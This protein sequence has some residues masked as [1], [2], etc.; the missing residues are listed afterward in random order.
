MNYGGN[1]P[2]WHQY[3]TSQTNEVTPST[4]NVNSG[5]LAYIPGVSPSTLNAISLNSEGLNK[6]QNNANYNPRNYQSFNNVSSNS[7]IPNNS[8]LASMVQMQNCIG[9]YG[10]PNTRNPMLDNINTSV[11]PRNTTI[12][13]VN[14]DI[15]YRSNQGPFNGPIGHLNGPNCNLNV[16]TGPRT[17]PGP[18]HGSRTNS[19]PGLGTNPN[20]ATGPGPMY[21]PNSRHGPASVSG[22]GSGPGNMGPRSTNVGPL[23]SGKPGPSSSCIP[24]KGMCCNSDSNINYQQWE[25]FGS[26]QN[27]GSYRDNVHPSNYQIEN[28]HFGNNCNFRKDNLDGKEVMGPVIPNASTIDHRRNFADYK[29]HKDHLVHRN[30][31]TS[32]GIFHNYSMQGYNY[33]AEHQK[34]PYP[35]K[36]HTKT[37][38]M[39]VQN[40]GMLKHQEQNFIAQQKFNNKQFQYQNGNMIPKGISTLNVNANMASSS[41]NPYFNSQYPRNISTEISHECQE[42]T[43]NTSMVN[44]MQGFAH[45]SPSQH[46]VYQQKIAMQKFSI[47][48]HL[49]ELGRIPGYQSHPKYKECI[50]RYREILKLQQSSGYQSSVQQIPRV[51][52]PANTSMPPINLQ[53]DQNG[54]LINSSYLPDNFSKLQHVSA[55]EQTPE[56]MDRQNKD[57]DIVMANEKCQ[58]SQ[59]SEQLMIPQQNEHVPS[60]CAETFQKQSQFSIHKDYNQNQPK[61][62]TS[63]SHSFNILST[64]SSNEAMMQQKASKEFANKP[65]LDVRQFLANWD[66]TD[67]EEGTTN[68]PD[69]IL[70]E[71]TPVVVVSYENIDL[72]S[73]TQQGTEVPRKNSFCSDETLESGKDGETNIITAQDCLTISYS[74]SDSSEIPKTSERTIGEGVVKPGSIIHCIS[75]GPDEIPTIHIVDNL[76]I[77]N[78]LGTPNDQVIQ[79]LE[80]QKAIPFF[81]ESSNSETM[82][83]ENTEQQDK[84]NVHVLSAN[85]TTSLDNVDKDTSIEDSNISE[86]ATI[87]MNNQELRVLSTSQK[88]NLGVGDNI[89]ELKKQH[90]F[91]ESH[92]PDDISLPDLPEC[93]PISTTLNTPIHSDTEESS[94]NMEE[95]LSISTNPIEVMQ[96]SPV[97]SFTQ[98]NSE[99]KV[100]NM[101]LGTIELEFQK[102]NRYKNNETSS[103]HIQ[104]VDNFEL[105]GNLK[106]KSSE[107]IKNKQLKSLGINAVRKKVCLIDGKENDT[108]IPDTC[109]VLTSMEYE[110]DIRQKVVDREKN[111]D[112]DSSDYTHNKEQKS[113]SRSTEAI[114]HRVQRSESDDNISS[115]P[116]LSPTVSDNESQASKS[117]KEMFRRRKIKTS[118]VSTNT[119]CLIPSELDQNIRKR[120]KEATTW[121]DKCINKY[122]DRN[123]SQKRDADHLKQSKVSDTRKFDD[124]SSSQ[125]GEHSVCHM[126]S[127][128]KHYSA[129][130][131]K[132][133]VIL[134]D[135][136]THSITDR[137]M[138]EKSP[139]FPSKMNNTNTKDLPKEAE[140]RKQAT[141]KAM[142]TLH[143]SIQS[144]TSRLL[145]KDLKGVDGDVR[146]TAEEMRLLKEYRKKKEKLYQAYNTHDDN[147][148]E[149]TKS[150]S[151]KLGDKICLEQN[152]ISSIVSRN[153]E[154]LVTQE[155]A[156][157]HSCSKSLIKNTDFGIQVANV[158]LKIKD[159][160]IGKELILGDKNQEHAKDPLEGIKIE[161]N[162]SCTDRNVKGQE[163]NKRL[164]YDDRSLYEIDDSLSYSNAL[165]SQRKSDAKEQSNNSKLPE[166]AHKNVF[167][168]SDAMIDVI[169]TNQGKR[170]AEKN[171]RITFKKDRRTSSEVNEEMN[172]IV[173]K[174]ACSLISESQSFSKTSRSNIFCKDMSKTE[175]IKDT[176]YAIDQLDVIKSKSAISNTAT[177]DANNKVKGKNKLED[178]KEDNRAREDEDRVARMRKQ[179]STSFMNVSGVIEKEIASVPHSKASVKLPESNFTE[180]RKKLLTNLNNL[181]F[182][183]GKYSELDLDRDCRVVEELDEEES[184]TGKWKKPKIDDILEDCDMFQSSSGYVNPIF[185]SIDKLENPHTVPVYTTKDGKISYS[186]NR[187]FTYHEL[188]MEARRRESYSSVKKS[189]YAD[190]WNSYYSSKFRKMN[191]RKRHHDL[192]DKK[193]YEYKNTKCLYDRKK[194][195]SDEFYGKNHVKYKDYIHS[196]RNDN[197][198]WSDHYK[199]DKMYSSSDSDDQIIDRSKYRTTE[200]NNS[201]KDPTIENKGITISKLQKD[202]I[203]I[204]E[205]DLESK[206]KEN[207]ADDSLNKDKS[208][209]LEETQMIQF[210]ILDMEENNENVNCKNAN[211]NCVDNYT[212]SGQ[213]DIPSTSLQLSQEKQTVEYSVNESSML[214]ESEI[215]SE[216]VQRVEGKNSSNECSTDQTID[217]VETLESEEKNV[218]TKIELLNKA[219]LL[220]EQVSL[221]DLEKKKDDEKIISGAVIKEQEADTEEQKKEIDINV[222]NSQTFLEPENNFENVEDTESNNKSEINQVG[223]VG[224]LEFENDITKKVLDPQT[225]SDN[226]F[227]QVSQESLD[228]ER[229]VDAFNEI[230]EESEENIIEENILE[231]EEEIVQFSEEVEI[232]NEEAVNK[233]EEEDNEYLENSNNNLSRDTFAMNQE[234]S[235]SR[236]ILTE[237]TINQEDNSKHISVELI[238]H[239]DNIDTN[240]D[241][242]N[243]AITEEKNLNDFSKTEIYPENENVTDIISN[244]N[245]IEIILSNIEEISVKQ[246]I[247]DNLKDEGEPN[248]LPT[249]LEHETKF[250][251]ESFEDKEMHILNTCCSIKNSPVTDVESCKDK[252]KVDEQKEE[253]IPLEQVTCKSLAHCSDSNIDMKAIP[254]LIIKKTDTPNSKSA[255]SLDYTETSENWD[256]Y[257]AKLFSELHPKIP[258]V[259]ITKNRSRS[260]TPVEIFQ[261]T[262]SDKTQSFLPE[263]NDESMDVDNSDF[264]SYTLKY[265]NCENKVPKVRIKLEDISSKDLKVYLKRK[266]TK[267]SIPKVRIKKLKTQESKRI[268]TKDSSETEDTDSDED[269]NLHELMSSDTEIERTPKSKLKRQ[270]DRSWS[271]EKNKGK[272][273]NI[274]KVFP[275]KTKR[276][277]EED[278]KCTAKYDTAISDELKK[279]FPQCIIE[280]IPKVIIKRTQIGAEF[281]CEISKSKKTSIIETAKWQPKVKLQRLDVLDNMVKDLKQSKITLSDKFDF[282]ARMKNINNEDTIDN[283]KVKLSRS[284]SVSNLSPTKYKRRR[285][286]DSSYMK[287]NTKSNIEFKSNLDGNVAIFKSDDSES[288]IIRKKENRKI[289]SESEQLYHS[290]NNE[291]EREMEEIITKHSFRN[292]LTNEDNDMMVVKEE[293]LSFDTKESTPLI[294]D[295][296]LDAAT[297]SHNYNDN[298]SSIIKV[299]SSDESQTTIEILPASP[300]NSDD[301][302]KNSEFESI[303]R[304]DMTDAMPTQLELELELIDNNN[305]CSEVFMSDIDYAS[306]SKSKYSNEGSTK[307]FFNE[308]QRS[309]QSTFDQNKYTFLMKKQHFERNTNDN[310]YCNDLLIKEVLAAKETLKKCLT[311]SETEDVERTSRPKTVAEKKQGLSFSFKDLGKS[312]D[313]SEEICFTSQNNKMKISD[314][315]CDIETEEVEENCFKQHEIY[316]V[317]CPTVS[318]HRNS[319]VPEPTTISLKSSKTSINNSDLSNRRN[320][321]A[322]KLLEIKSVKKTNS[323]SQKNND[324]SNN[325]KVKEDNMPLLVPEFV[326]NFDSSSDRDSSRSPPVITNQEEVEHVAENTKLVENKVISQIEKIEENKKHS[327][328]NCE[329][330]IADIITQLAYHEKATIKHKKYCNL[331]ERWFP[332]TSR[333][334][335]HLAGY[336]HRYI[337]LTQRKSI[338]ALFILFTG[339]PCPRLLPANVIRN[340][341]S[342]GE[343]T[344]L[345]IAVQDVAKC[346][347]YIQQNQKTKE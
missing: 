93:T 340:D 258:K 293:Y 320:S 36:E 336:Q 6:H 305:T 200:V 307:T 306:H 115:N 84:D 113:I 343:L 208:M 98:L 264:E 21:G 221:C 13:T 170:E 341:C 304:M 191:K 328:N 151:H 181:D 186:P 91:E 182:K 9:H 274:S 283:S 119:N 30:Y 337:E 125:G 243:N 255:C 167:E 156:K 324:N 97:I 210:Q 99:N 116:N 134:S 207:E 135:K 77:S 316:S 188:M 22:S 183:F 319:N 171:L 178:D 318:T 284:N 2:D 300:N 225:D 25:K 33:S 234:V 67:D 110:L 168:K 233:V 81:R 129:A 259:I 103:E 65:D 184:Y 90:S 261:K 295:K 263:Q 35:V 74:A 303:N 118:T 88:D 206:S 245:E 42:T 229:P 106:A 339:K 195:Y 39:N 56:N 29:Y 265:N 250:N 14:D 254:K 330:T 248:D 345:Q 279:K 322:E 102:E 201:K 321:N 169:E 331:C 313:K 219:S 310:F 127:Q 164:L 267:R 278:S 146:Y 249:V 76:E 272:N 121:E 189:H 277:K 286:S 312:S 5:H 8:P 247:T 95:D 190:T 163:Q 57:Q 26:Y 109:T 308:F 64:N 11:D 251:Q 83:L 315:P 45:N 209:D 193:K 130:V 226:I 213:S 145:Q 288:K 19:G 266:A 253:Q 296:F 85:Y 285:F 215:T 107:A 246:V 62:Q 20:N 4:Q 227:D 32:S 16:S 165:D 49:R 224:I 346:V 34:Y 301:E 252:T 41:Q 205:L 309:S 58:Q 175:V 69:T 240:S 180:L 126:I 262:K 257:D 143:E 172:S 275:K 334:R 270:E 72:S 142:S 123:L 59:Q 140:I 138:N 268:E 289:S 38:N 28:R 132:D 173:P 299:D 218:V 73:K 302:A 78:I 238:H 314:S 61:V 155:E 24:C 147:K 54:M 10:S 199:M 153:S 68:L 105:S 128:Y 18:V 31:S 241:Q 217:K 71:T 144:Q 276:T 214:N 157:S 329:M 216:N 94:Q 187:R 177:V 294:E 323:D 325:T 256:K 17:G 271:P 101:S 244:K 232:S 196:I 139:E 150:K 96:N 51:A 104:E 27:N 203:F 133:N 87:S 82:A 287:V 231:C 15:G 326:L 158:N 333:H 280:K 149:K 292:I 204:N 347:E 120:A 75:N 100:K 211:N 338:H 212:S 290:Q 7:A 114:K 179:S 327:Y 50:L 269:K 197:A 53:F 43:D 344:P 185:S 124:S 12:G 202:D 192:S 223:I 162:V 117:D 161:I 79:T 311:R 40:S 273:S 236:A 112:R 63:E 230:V 160:D 220:D 80:K 148:N 159:N 198:I 282:S 48:N 92:N 47:E 66:E 154:N 242:I 291:S 23:P 281:K 60:S 89:V 176:N 222:S 111:S 174:E 137:I 1:M 136:R 108:K 52:T 317:D 86:T 237:E 194:N 166:R 46:Q 152:S 342:I 131:I 228:L 55:V 239:Q 260:A 44:R 37:N 141:S 122:V 332:T 335:R 298:D 70:S 235:E 3:N 297:R